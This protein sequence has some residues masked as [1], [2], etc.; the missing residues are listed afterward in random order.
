M[1]KKKLIGENIRITGCYVKKKVSFLSKLEIQRK[2][3]SY[4]DKFEFKISKAN[5]AQNTRKYIEFHNS[6]NIQDEK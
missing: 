2:L 4:L 1:F 5:P 6:K 3:F